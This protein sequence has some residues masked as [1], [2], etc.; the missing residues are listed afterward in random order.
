MCK[1]ASV[2]LTLSIGALLTSCDFVEYWEGRMRGWQEQGIG[3][4]RQRA[5]NSDFPYDAHDGGRRRC[6]DGRHR[7]PHE[8][9]CPDEP[10]KSK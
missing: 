9:G 3:T 7:S 1:Q 8:S 2:A 10:A 6:P 5:P 4:Y